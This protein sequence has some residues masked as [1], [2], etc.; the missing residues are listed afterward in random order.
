MENFKNL[1][2]QVS[3][4]QKKYDE[5]AE[6]SGEHFNVFDILGVTSNELS[7]S[8]ILTNLLN[9]KGKHGQKE[10]FLKIFLNLIKDKFEKSYQKN[11][12]ENFDAKNS[13][14]IKEKYAGKVDYEAEQGGKID[15]VIY[16]GKNNII[17]ENKIYAIDQPK[18]LVRYNEH[19]KMAPIIYL[20]LMGNEP[21]IDSCGSLVSGINYVCISYENVIK[22][23]LELCIKEMVNRPIIRETFNQ[24]LYLIKSL[25]NQS[26]NNKMSTEIIKIMKTNIQSSFEIVNNI[27]A[28]KSSLYYEFMSLIKEY[29][30]EKMIVNDSWVDKDKEYG[31]FLKPMI[32]E[33]NL[34]QICIIFELKNYSGLYVGIAYDK[35]LSENDKT[36][37]RKKYKENGFEESDFWIWKYTTN[38]NWADNPVIWDSVAKGKESKEYKEVINKIEE[39]LNIYNS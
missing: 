25:T 24:Y 36:L 39:I 31:L 2:N 16:D 26:T 17:I 38:C 27:S 6:Y 21:S 37:L 12:I 28:L 23:W 19:D 8:A 29:G 7:H 14:A 13:I 32:W 22:E 3:I 1:L 18:Q 35:E 30:K 4:I 5:M 11:I 20:T 10:L 9:A 33:K 15:I 34:F